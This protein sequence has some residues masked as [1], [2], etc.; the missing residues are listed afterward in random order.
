MLRRRAAAS[1]DDAD[2]VHDEAPGVRRHVLRRAQVD[3]APLDVARLSRVGLCR[4]P[5]AGD[6][7]HALDRVEHRCRTDGTVD[8]DHR[9]AA[10]LELRREL[11]GRRAVE[12]VAVLLGRHLRDDRDVRHA[13]HGIDRRADFVQI[14]ERLEDEEIDAAVGKRLRLLAEIVARLVDAGLA[15]RLDADAERSDGAGDVRLLARSVPRD[16]RR[17]LVDRVQPIGEAERSELDAVRAERVGLDDVG[18]RADVLLVHFSDQVRL[19]QVQ[20]V[21][22]LVDEDALRIEHRPHRAVAHEDPLVERVEKRFH[23]SR[24]SVLNVSASM[25]K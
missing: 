15:P 9:R 5:A 16:F 22:A 8:A 6:G 21:E 11:L 23:V 20:R 13:P 7:G 19:R 18:A 17:L 2:V 4:Q 1:A 10:L 3:V 24:R 25:S 12:R 14:A